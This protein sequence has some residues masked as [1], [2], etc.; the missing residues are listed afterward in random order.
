MPPNVFTNSDAQLRLWVSDGSTG[1]Q[2]LTPDQRLASAGYA[3]YSARAALAL[4]V[5]PGVVT[6]TGTVVQVNTGAGLTGGPITASGTISIPNGGISNAMLQNSAMTVTAAGG[7]TGGGSVALGGSTSLSANLNHDP[8]LSGNG[9]ASLLGL[10]LA[11]ANTWTG[12]QTFMGTVT[13]SISGNAAGFTGALAGDV[14]GTQNATIITNLSASKIFGLFRW[15]TAAGTSQQAQSNT[16]YVVTNATQ[17]TVT[18]PAAPNVGDTVRVSC[19]GAGG[20]KIGQNS[21]QSIFAGNFVSLKIG[22][23]WTNHGPS[24]NWNDVASSA[25]GTKFVAVV[26]G[27]QI[28]TSTDSGMTW[29]ARQTNQAWSAVASSGDGSKLAAVVNGGQIYTSIDSG[30]TW[31][32]RDTNRAWSAVASSI[33]GAKLAAVVNGGQIY[34]S[35][36]SGATW[37]PQFSSSAWVSVASSADGTKLLAGVGNG[38]LYTSGDSGVTWSAHGPGGAWYGVASSSDGSRLVAASRGLQVYTSADSGATWSPGGASASWNSVACSADGTRLVAVANGAQIYTSTDFGQTWLAH[39]TFRTW[40]S[41]ACSADAATLVA[42]VNG[43]QIYVSLPPLITPAT[44]TTP[45][46]SGYLTGGQGTAIELQYVG[47]NQFFT[48]SHEGVLS[49]Y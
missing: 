40:Q 42:V 10:N 21:G 35:A 38:Q 13:G 37:T 24:A 34:T 36:D 45:G 17:V 46:T 5:A 39:D 3:M 12:P 6:N 22:Q 23:S 14:T 27:G 49:A 48:L 29:L 2:Q 11:N 47:N 26:N 43:G 8:T 16:G 25:D 18:L 33:D 7:L 30:A 4:S 28:Y 20:W 44:T 31:L 41:V 1:F 19:P 15:Q 9:G 32:A